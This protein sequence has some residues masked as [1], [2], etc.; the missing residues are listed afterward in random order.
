MILDHGWGSPSEYRKWGPYLSF[1]NSAATAM[2]VSW[3]SKFFSLDSWIEYGETIDCGKRIK[4]DMDALPS[5]MHTFLLEGLKPDTTYYFK[6]SR[7]EDMQEQEAPVYTFK[8]GPPD[9]TATQPVDFSIVSDMHNGGNVA[10]PSIAKNVPGTR[11]ILDCGDCITHG[12]EEEKW[13]DFFFQFAPIC[14]KIAFMNATGNHDTDHPETY[15][16]FIQTFHHPY[17]DTKLGAFY[18]FVYGNA[19]FIMLDST[20]AG[21]TKGKQGVVSD[22]QLEWLEA[23]L[24][25]F[26]SKG[27]WIIICTHHTIYSTGECSNLMNLYELAYK[28]LFD[29]YKVDCVFY[30]HD[31]AFEV[32]W[33]GREKPWGGTHYCL[34]GN[35]GEN[36]GTDVRDASKKPP[37]RFT[38][39]GRTYI[40]ERDGILDGQLSNDP[41]STRIIKESFVYGILESGFT[42]CRIHGDECEMRMIGRDSQ[43]YFEDKF[44]RT[45]CGK[46]FHAP[47]HMQQF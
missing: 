31:H 11:F 36:L 34:V 47:I 12:G 17:H 43:V 21:Q 6:I 16:H 32:Y 28:D 3:Q 30:G 4:K 24:A 22:E 26:S 25:R 2:H 5:A 45:G 29:E 33:G 14:T 7:P 38:W 20:N 40:P 42:H 1:G 18:Y 41:V 23:T 39:K 8:T 37:P 13:N 35:G 46:V 15:A 44:K 10:Y 9:G 27:Y 19:A